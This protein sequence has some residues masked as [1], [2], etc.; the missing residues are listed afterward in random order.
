MIRKELR[1][2]M[3]DMAEAER[4]LEREAYKWTTIQAHYAMFHAMRALLYLATFS[5]ETARWL[6]SQ[7][8]AAIAEIE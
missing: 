1:V 6:L 3:E 5:E 7:G 8:Q 2:G 4:G